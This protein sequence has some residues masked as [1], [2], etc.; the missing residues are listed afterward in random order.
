[1]AAP[2]G[3]EDDDDFDEEGF[4]LGSEFDAIR[5][6]KAFDPVVHSSTAPRGGFGHVK[7]KAKE[8][9]KKFRRVTDL[10]EEADTIPLTVGDFQ[11]AIVRG[12]TDKV[13]QGCSISHLPDLARGFLKTAE[14]KQ[15]P[16]AVE[17]MRCKLDELK[18]DRMK[19]QDSLKDSYKNIIAKIEALRNE[20]NQILDK[21]EKKTVEQLDS[22]M[23][24]LEKYHT[25][26]VMYAARE[27]RAQMLEILEGKKHTS[28][29]KD[30]TLDLSIG[31]SQLGIRKKILDGIHSVHKK[32]WDNASLPTMHYNKQVSCGEALAMVAN[33]SKHIKYICTTMAYLQN[34][35]SRSPAILEQLQKYNMFCLCMFLEKKNFI[36]Y[37]EKK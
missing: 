32:D 37:N 8:P 28:P 13:K 14:F 12:H 29:H 26:P 21:L 34:Q 5:K 35:L 7:P 19:D 6:P 33:I 22:M 10:K 17:K 1:M 18:N 3:F 27:G 11:M 30:L 4:C 9:E 15:L 2:G 36:L 20:I 24:D 31:V 23:E 25:S 16:A